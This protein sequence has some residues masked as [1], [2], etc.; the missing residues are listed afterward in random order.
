MTDRPTATILVVDDTEASRYAVA[1][2]LR[3]AQFKVWEAGT[4]A[5]A[6]KLAAQKP[7]VILLNINLPDMSGYEACR[8]IKENPDTASIVILHLSASFVESDN[9]SEGLEGGADGYLIYPLAARELL[10]NVR[11]ML[12]VRKAERT[13]S[14]SASCCTSPSRASVTVS[15]RRTSTVS[16]RSSTRWPVP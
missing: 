6:L 1:R 10:A 16:S 7:D 13:A 4:A 8:R 11:A 15:S 12:R 2:I 3:Q 9:R 5:E 14:A